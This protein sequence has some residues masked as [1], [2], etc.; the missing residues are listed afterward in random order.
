MA[1]S[2]PQTKLRPDND[3]TELGE[4]IYHGQRTPVPIDEQNRFIF[5]FRLIT[6]KAD[7]I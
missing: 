5:K 3:V 6:R 2:G 4:S 1:E 7:E